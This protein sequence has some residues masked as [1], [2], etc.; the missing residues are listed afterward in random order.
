M[1]VKNAFLNGDLEEEVYIKPPPGYQHPKDKVC[2]LRRALYGLK[3]APCAWF[4]K[5]SNTMNQLNFSCSP[6]DSALF[7]RSTAHGIVLLLLYIDDITITGNDNTGVHELKM[8]L[9][10]QFEMKDLSRLNYF[11]G[12]EVHHRSDGISL[13]QV[14]YATDLISR[15]HLSDEEVET[16]PIEPNVHYTSIDGTLLDN[17]THYRQLVGSLIYLAITRPDIAYAVHVISQFMSEPHTTYYVAVLRIIQYIRG[18]LYHGLHFFASSSLTL[19]AYSDADWGGD[20]DDRRSTTG[21]C[22][23]LGHSLISWRSK[24]QTLASRS[25][26]ESE[27][28]ALADTTAEVLHDREIRSLRHSSQQWRGSHLPSSKVSV[29]D[30]R[31]ETKPSNAKL[32]RP[33]L[34]YRRLVTVRQG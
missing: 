16:T 5:F 10:Q 19:R 1:D 29:G 27:Y 20:H 32:P 21:F 30:W 24:K 31:A 15:A 18:T 14:K 11:L 28:R 34:C 23:F 6:H 26:A 17:P 12:I 7:V 9:G 22:I 2:C 13:S 33:D 25:S 4:A 8:Y 3:Q